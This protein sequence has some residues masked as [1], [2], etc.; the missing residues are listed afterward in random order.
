M[1]N[2][3][4]PKK[5]W[6][7]K[8]ES[9]VF[10]SNESSSDD[11]EKKVSVESPTPNKFS[12]SDVSQNVNSNIP[13]GMVMPNTNGVFDEKFYNSFLQI[14]EANNID[15]IDYYEFSKTK[16]NLEAN[17]AM[18]P[19]SYQTAFFALQATSPITKEK[20]LE[21]ADF[22]LSKL[23]EEEKS[24]ATEMQNEVN[25]E[26]ASRLN[27]ATLKQE[28]ILKK[29]EEINKLQADMGIL[30]GEIGALNVEAQQVQTKI[31]STAKNFKVSLDI[32]K[33]QINIDK[34]NISTYLK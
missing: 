10:T 1:E 31:D 14:I 9:A 12:Y 18:A 15:G 32:L 3:N 26:V 20:L 16:K 2:E 22:Y 21:T 24:F 4:K 8:L 13:S 25:S 28:E 17:G 6:L 23:D 33:N 7:K 29:Q 27:K 5:S 19:S 34:Q 30:Q 11:V